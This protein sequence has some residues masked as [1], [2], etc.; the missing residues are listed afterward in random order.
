MGAVASAYWVSFAK[1]G[2]PSVDGR[3]PWPRYDP[4]VDRVL[5]FTNTGVVVG[6]DPLK[7][8]LDLWQK[9][10]SSGS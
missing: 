2:D 3:T 6:P 9:M 8:R 5:N 1:T 7:A 10:W 4:S